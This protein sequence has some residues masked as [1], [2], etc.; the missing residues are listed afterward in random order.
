MKRVGVGKTRTQRRTWRDCAL[1]DVIARY[2]P[3]LALASGVVMEDS[4]EAVGLGSFPYAVGQSLP[5][6]L[7][8]SLRQLLVLVPVPF[9]TSCMLSSFNKS[10]LSNFYL[11]FYVFELTLIVK[12][13]SSVTLY[14]T[15]C[16]RPKIA[17]V[18]ASRPMTGCREKSKPACHL[19]NI[20]KQVI[21]PVH[22]TY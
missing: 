15:G 8:A 11:S 17:D 22:A 20:K 4:P 10:I 7:R 21:L 13:L 1:N 14:V 5:S 18:S 3:L 6:F 2:N 19:K 9:L 16:H 12:K